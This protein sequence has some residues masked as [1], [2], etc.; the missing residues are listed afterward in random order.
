MF[1]GEKVY[2]NFFNQEKYV[3]LFSFDEVNHHFGLDRE[4]GGNKRFVLSNSTVK[5]KVDSVIRLKRN[6][7]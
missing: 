1:G 2:K 5:K 7:A 3:E 6:H 4:K